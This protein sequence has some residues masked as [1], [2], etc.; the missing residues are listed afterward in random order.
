MAVGADTFTISAV[1]LLIV[2]AV[3]FYLFTRIKQV[4]KK[5]AL[6]EGIL[7]DLKTATE[8][9][10]LGFPAGFAEVEE[11]DDE[12]AEDD[13]EAFLP[14]KPDEDAESSDSDN[15]TGLNAVRKIEIDELIANA[16]TSIPSFDEAEEENLQSDS[17]SVQV[18]KMDPDLES[19]SFSELST[20]AKSRGMTV[21][22]KMR[23]T[24]LLTALRQM[25]VATSLLPVPP[26]I[27]PASVA[28]VIEES[29]LE[30]DG[31]AAGSTLLSS[32]SLMAS[33]L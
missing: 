7:L 20:L 6:M 29:M 17:G 2:G 5:L 23:K 18:T 28:P 33:P 27:Q 22:S 14:L 10:F 13:E 32:S 12:E 15:D 8:A 16:A 9:G 25:E 19:M 4:E 26:A 24:Q 21:T 30:P 11:A 31:M 1:V 3:C